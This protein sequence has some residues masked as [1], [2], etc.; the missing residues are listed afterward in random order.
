[1]IKLGR[2]EVW[3]IDLQP[4]TGHEQDGVRPA[5][6]ISDNLFNM[7][8]SGMVVV[9]PITSKCRG[10]PSHVEI[11]YEFMKQKSYIKTEDIRAISSQRLIKKLGS[12]ERPVLEKVE[13]CLKLILGFV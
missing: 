9:V 11:D 12:V 7:S 4:A 2:G 3:L 6:I 10:I 1:M 5:L 13:E 8:L